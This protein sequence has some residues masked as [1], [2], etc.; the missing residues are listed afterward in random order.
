MC[1]LQPVMCPRSL[2]K[3]QSQ[4]HRGYYNKSKGSLSVRNYEMSVLCTTQQEAAYRVHRHMGYCCTPE[5]PPPN[6]PRA[7]EQGDVCFRVWG[8]TTPA[9]EQGVL[10]VPLPYTLPPTPY[11]G[12]AVPFTKDGPGRDG[13]DALGNAW[14]DY[15]GGTA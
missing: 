4:R 12:G 9:G 13:I 3:T 10:W 8:G 5:A 11:K 7:L 6:A 2:L 1:H 14:D 15:F